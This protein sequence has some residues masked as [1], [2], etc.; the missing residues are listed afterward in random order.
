M[1]RSMRSWLK[2]MGFSLTR[3]RTGSVVGVGSGAYGLLWPIT[4]RLMAAIATIAVILSVRASNQLTEGEAELWL[5]GD[6]NLG[7]GGRKRLDG[8][9]GMVQGADGIV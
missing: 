2:L 9:A 1:V 3:K 4:L 8:I 7:D 5:D 6:V